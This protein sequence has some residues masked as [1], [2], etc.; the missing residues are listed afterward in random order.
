MAAFKKLITGGVGVSKQ[1]V[2][3]IADMLVVVLVVVARTLVGGDTH[4]GGEMGSIRWIQFVLN[5]TLHLGFHL[6]HVFSGN[7]AQNNV[8]IGVVAH[9][10]GEIVVRFVAADSRGGELCVVAHDDDE[11]QIMFTIIV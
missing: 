8:R 9:Q 11:C 10:F 4:E 1:L 2:V 6:C 3:D 5:E 7:L